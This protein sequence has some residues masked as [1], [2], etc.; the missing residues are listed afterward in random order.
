MAS[1]A[2]K[3]SSTAYPLLFQ[4]KSSTN[5]IDGVLLASATVTLSK[6]GGAF[7][8][9]AGAVTEVANGWYKVAGNA[10]DSGTLGPLI[11]H[12]E[13]EG[14][15]PCDV[16]YEVVAYNPQVAT[17][18]GLS[19]LPTANPGAADGVFIAGTNAATAVDITGDITGGITGDITG[20]LSGSV[21]S[22]T[23]G[24]TVTTNNDKTGYALSDVGLDTVAI[25]DASGVPTTFTE[26]MNQLWQR[27]FRKTVKDASAGTIAVYGANGTTVLTTQTWTD[28]SDGNET[29]GAGA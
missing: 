10:T 25:T 15:D 3:Q 13:A 18:L 1:Y 23:G 16:V 24:V 22:V 29:L 8:T 17:N 20:N 28:L 4:L 5:H 7:D 11:L 19:A 12:A 26:R 2:V 14:A 6:S 9:P 21:G 27:F